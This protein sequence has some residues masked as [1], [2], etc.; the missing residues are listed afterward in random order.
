MLAL[1]LRLVTSLYF[2]GRLEESRDLLIRH[3]PRVDALGDPRI[4]GEFYFWLANIAGQ[5]GESTGVGHFA[6]RAIEEAERA[7]DA[8]TIGKARSR[9]GLGGLLHRP[10]RGGGRA[11]AGCGRA[12]EATEEWWWL[13]Y[14]LCWEA[15]NQMSL[16]AFDAALRSSRRRGG[17]GASGRTR[18]CRA[19][20][21]G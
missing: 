7:G 4:A 15:V 5:I 2:Q 3:R 8:T 13:G 17:S 9:A 16:G 6:A 14:A 20:A 12:L 19:T 1:V 18:A 10:I 21:P 11:R